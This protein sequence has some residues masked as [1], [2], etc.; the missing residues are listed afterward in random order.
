M[1]ECIVYPENG[2]E[3]EE[4]VINLPTD[5]MTRNVL[6]ALKLLISAGL[7]ISSRLIDLFVFVFFLKK[8]KY[9]IF[10]FV[11]QIALNSYVLRSYFLASFIIWWVDESVNPTTQF[12]CV[13]PS[14]R[15]CE[16]KP[17]TQNLLTR[18]SLFV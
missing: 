12:S 1:R 18:Q 17:V 15:L 16:I 9:A 5:T 2:L 7:L 13:I 11:K 4:E 8:I 14:I 6:I 10:C 3:F